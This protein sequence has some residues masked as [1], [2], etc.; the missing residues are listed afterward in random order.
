MAMEQGGM[1]QGAAQPAQG[2]APA[3]GG[4][5]DAVKELV[6][7]LVQGLGMLSQ[8]VGQSGN[9]EGASQIE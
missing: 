9:P 3:Q 4:G 6:G 5:A 1:P 7:N 8:V 2:Q